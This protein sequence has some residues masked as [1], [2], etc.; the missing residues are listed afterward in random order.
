MAVTNQTVREAVKVI[1]KYVDQQ[2]LE[3]I[4]R[5]LSEVPG[6]KAFRDTVEMVARAA[7]LEDAP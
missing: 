2:T 6:S 7:L 4:L 5:D 1:R 3:D